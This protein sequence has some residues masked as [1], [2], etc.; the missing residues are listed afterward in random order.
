MTHTGLICEHCGVQLDVDDN[1]CRKCGNVVTRH[2]PEPVVNDER[3]KQKR[4]RRGAL[5]FSFKVKVG[6]RVFTEE[7]WK[8][9]GKDVIRA[10]AQALLREYYGQQQRAIPTHPIDDQSDI[11]PGNA[12]SR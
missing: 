6:D 2:P 7:E 1:F 11:N 10:M 12:E 8:A 5:S 9:G 4:I 3:P